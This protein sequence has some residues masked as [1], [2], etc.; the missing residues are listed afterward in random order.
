MHWL[1]IGAPRSECKVRTCELD[2]ML[3]ATLLDQAPGQ[4]RALP[5]RHHPSHD[6]A[7]E[8]VHMMT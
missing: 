4:G 1:V 6:V 3:Q 5:I 2:A 8:D 7:A